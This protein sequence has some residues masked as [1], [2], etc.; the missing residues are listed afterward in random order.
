MT[1]RA[2]SS[3]LPIVFDGVTVTAGGVTILDN[4]ALTLRRARPRC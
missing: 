4:I 2:P 3:E 1:M